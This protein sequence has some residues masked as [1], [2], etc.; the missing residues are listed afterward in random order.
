MRDVYVVGVDTIKFGKYLEKS[1]KV[2][3]QETFKGCLK[4]AGIKQKDIK[5]NYS[6][7]GKN[8]ST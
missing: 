2:L 1:T 6:R 8:V 4:D 7:N 3:A 5:R